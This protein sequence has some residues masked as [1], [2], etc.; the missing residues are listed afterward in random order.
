MTTSTNQ[1]YSM[2]SRIG[3]MLNLRLE[4]SRRHVE[5][6]RESIVLV[7]LEIS[8]DESTKISQKN[9][10]ICLVIDCSGSM[11]DDG[12]M[13]EAKNDA[14]SLVRGLPSDHMV[15][16]VAFDD[17]VHVILDPK[18]ASERQYIENMIHSIKTGYATAMHAGISKAFDLVE[19]NRSLSSSN[20]INRLVVITDGLPTAGPCEDEDF[21]QQA[22]E[23][24]NS[25]VTTSTV[26]IGADY[27]EELLKKVAEFGGGRWEHVSNTN[28]LST[29]MN[30][31][32]TQMQNTIITNPQLRIT[33]LDTAKLIEANT[34]RPNTG[35]IDNLQESGNVIHIGLK[36]IVKNEPH[37][38]V[39]K[40]KIPA[41]NGENL[42]LLTAEIFEGSNIVAG[43]ETLEITYTLDRD[44]CSAE[45]KSPFNSFMA[46]RHTIL[47]EREIHG[48][49]DAGKEADTILK[50]LPNPE[51]EDGLAKDTIIHANK[52]AGK[53]S[54]DLTESEKKELSHQ[55][56]MIDTMVEKLDEAI[57]DLKNPEAKEDD[58]GEPEFFKEKDKKKLDEGEEE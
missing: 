57:D 19:Q 30:E 25:G 46:T 17:D 8:S 12:K 7:Q 52:I 35:P 43:P 58:P 2:Y 4:Q 29:V 39:F 38:L 33:L 31:Q 6:N 27:D 36:D 14:I 20:T 37:A 11:E 56:T 54:P 26:G 44:L 15:S 34:A 40:I 10:H 48:D 1:S 45:N 21:I 42:P 47:R 32:A 41:G 28:N 51:L 18:P 5:S 13:D 49:P 16:I 55:T 9:H 24:R 23:I 22:K 50:I 53:I 3:S